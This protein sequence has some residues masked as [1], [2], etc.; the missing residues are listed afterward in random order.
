[1][2]KAFTTDA[3]ITQTAAESTYCE[4]LSFPEG[5]LSGHDARAAVSRV[6]KP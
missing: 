6:A 4:V 2:Q 3:L 1:M 5:R